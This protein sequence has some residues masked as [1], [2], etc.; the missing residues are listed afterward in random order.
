MH[1]NINKLVAQIKRSSSATRKESF[2]ITS[3]N[4]NHY[5]NKIPVEEDAFN[6]PSLAENYVR[7]EMNFYQ[8]GYSN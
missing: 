2:K 3:K 7:E 4:A 6:Q 5:A 8:N 1:K